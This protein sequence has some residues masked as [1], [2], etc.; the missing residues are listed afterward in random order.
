MLHY[1][2]DSSTTTT[3]TFS[4]KHARDTTID[5][6]LEFLEILRKSGESIPTKTLQS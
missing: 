1:S 3:V 4:T 2:L 5:T 6:L